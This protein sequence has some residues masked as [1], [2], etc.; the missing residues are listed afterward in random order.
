MEQVGWAAVGLGW[1]TQ[2]AFLPAFRNAGRDARLVALVSGSDRKRNAVADRHGV[3]R[4][5]RYAYDDFEACLERDDVQAIYIGLPND[6]HRE[7]AV[8]AAERGVHVL[9]EKP[10]APSAE[11]CD[12]M[13][14]AAR[15]ND[16]KLMV[17]YR[18]HFDPANL[19]AV[20]LV[21]GGALGEPRYFSSV[22]S[23]QVKPGDIRLHPQERGGGPL[24]DIGIYCLNAT[25]YL[26]RAEPE[27][28]W[29][30][31]ATGADEKGR[32]D[33]SPE[34]TTTVLRFDGGRLAQFTC[35]FGASDVADYRVVGSDGDL[36]V[37]NAYHFRGER[38]LEWGDGDH[39]REERFPDADQFGPQIRHFS[40]S[41]REDAD[42]GSVSGQEGRTDVALIEAMRESMR[43]G[44]WVDVH[45]SARDERP[46]SSQAMHC[47][48]IEAPELIEAST[49]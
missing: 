30:T 24:Y 36:L 45:I 35:S 4:D 16:V 49:P 37:R 26:F 1:I 12:R 33:E 8:R 25:R 15:A 31:S 9:C 29:C 28:V 47:D 7:Y 14:D 32:F 22:F 48:A 10:M 13:I 46:Q 38:V 19:R 27:S 43:T 6:R 5:A 42:V 18:L 23:Q 44:E 20:E 34:A 17:A 40:R 21:T 3:A 11:D 39:R 2:A 41:I